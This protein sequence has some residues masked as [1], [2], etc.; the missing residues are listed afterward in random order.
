VDRGKPLE[1]IIVVLRS[2]VYLFTLFYVSF[3]KNYKHLSAQL[4]LRRVISYREAHS[5]IVIRNRSAYKRD[6]H[7]STLKLLSVESRLI[8]NLSCTTTCY[9]IY[10][11][12][13]AS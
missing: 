6:T 3:S 13:N 7:N 10:F 2:P 9:S 4:S 11:N 8:H 1:N 5:S 12:K